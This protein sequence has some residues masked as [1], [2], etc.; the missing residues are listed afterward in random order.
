M[1]RRR[2]SPVRWLLAI[3]TIAFAQ[4]MGVLP[5]G[6]ARLVGRS[7]ATLALYTV[8]RVRRVGLANLDLAYGD[9][10]TPAQKR[11]ILRQAVHNLGVVAAEFPRIGQL[12][13]PFLDKHVTLKGIEHLPAQGGC[14]IIAAHHGNWE[15]MAPIM[16]TTGRP[17]LEVV[18]PLDDPRLNAF[19]DRTRRSGNVETLPKTNAGAAI[20][21]LLKEGSAAGILV[22]QSPRDNGAPARFFGQ[23]C[24][25]TVGAAVLAVRARVPVIP[26]SMT[27]QADGRYLFEVEPELELVRTGRPSANIAQN[28]QRCQDAIEAIVRRTPGQWLWLHRRWKSRD[29]LEREWAERTGSAQ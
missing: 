12:H 27:R 9:T 3:L 18:R 7:L 21:R 11:V 20:L 24:W 4:L 10:L 19:I 5:L 13:G 29:R 23:P 28:A 1:P 26:V 15:W 14:I 25:A 8:P 2:N 16:T 6:A 17:A 22:D